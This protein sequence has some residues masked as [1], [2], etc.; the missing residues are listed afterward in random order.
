MVD[1]LPTPT[2]YSPIMARKLSQI[3]IG[4]DGAI[5]NWEDTEK[6]GTVDQEIE[7]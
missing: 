7:E 5:E 4:E 3:G 1:K 6:I 2:Y